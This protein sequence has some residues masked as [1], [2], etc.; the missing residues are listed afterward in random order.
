MFL[1]TI[2]ANIL[3]FVRP[4]LLVCDLVSV[5]KKKMHFCK[6]FNIFLSLIYVFLM[7]FLPGM[8]TVLVHNIEFS[9][10]P[11]T[12]QLVMLCEDNAQL[13]LEADLSAVCTTII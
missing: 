1:L 6:F 3:I 5:C 12:T 8:H 4:V 2:H 10:R 13:T 9:V 11:R 7:Q